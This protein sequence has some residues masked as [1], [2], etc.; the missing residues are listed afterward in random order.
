MTERHYPLSD[1]LS[2]IDYWTEELGPTA[3]RDDLWHAV[4]RTM[5]SLDEAFCLDCEAHTV[6]IREYY[7]VDDDLWKKYGPPRGMLCLGCLEGRM[8]RSLVASDFTD[9]PINRY[10]E[11]SERFKQR[12]PDPAE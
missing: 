5:D 9:A 1:F 12:L 2:G 6:E 10:G 11:R 7:M 4:I 3:T 8:G